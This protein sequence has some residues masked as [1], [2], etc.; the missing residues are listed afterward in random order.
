MKKCLII[1][2]VHGREFWI[3][4]CKRVD[5]FEKV[6]FLGDYLDHYPPECVRVDSDIRITKDS[7]ISNFESIIQF[8]KD[9]PQKCILLIGNHDCPYY[10]QRYYD[11]SDYHCR[12]DYD[13]HDYISGIFKDNKDLF[14]FAYE[15]NKCL[16]SHA[17]VTKELYEHVFQDLMKPTAHLDD[18]INSYYK[19]EKHQGSDLY[20]C[21]WFRG[22]W[23]Q[24]GS[25]VWADAREHDDWCPNN[26]NKQVFGHTYCKSPIILDKI[27]MLD[28]GYNAYVIDENLLI[29]VYK[30]DGL[31]V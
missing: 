27:A 29:E 4:P 15:W 11:F 28:T 24:Y 7:E 3:D 12:H 14:T 22:G 9:N 21:S 17:G 5:D 26:I 6:I 10:S 30:E 16:F 20:K 8:K 2:D 1:P 31:E 23:D 13:N 19:K 25:I 18:V